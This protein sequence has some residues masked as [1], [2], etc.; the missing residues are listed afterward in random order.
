MMERHVF[1]HDGLALSWLDSGGDGRVLVALHAHWMEGKTFAR[2]ARDLAPRWRVIA[3]DLRG[4]GYSDHAS[5]Y[6]RNDYLGDLEML[7]DHLDVPSAVLLGNSLG[8]VNAYQFAARHPDRVG[9]LIIEDIG[10]EVT[11]TTDF[12]LA[13][14]GAF[15]TREELA[16]RIGPR[17][18]PYLADSF[19]STPAGWRLAF[20]PRDMVASQRHLNGD[21]WRDWLATDCPALLIRGRDSRLTS[22]THM[23]RMAARRPNTRLRVLDGGHVVHIDNPEGFAD[24]VQAFLWELPTRAGRPSRSLGYFGPPEL[25]RS[26]RNIRLALP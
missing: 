6:T 24:A 12:V 1:Q 21:H 3:P 16:A 17:L 22:Q 9:G 14:N 4:H 11:E 2:L 15:R 23:E 25:A 20:N 19:R 7:L 10:A 26:Q 5:S 8:G 13:W 18:A